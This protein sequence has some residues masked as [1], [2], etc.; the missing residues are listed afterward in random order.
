MRRVTNL[1]D[2]TEMGILEATGSVIDGYSQQLGFEYY[3]DELTEEEEE[4]SNKLCDE[5]YNT[6]GDIWGTARPPPSLREGSSERC[7]A[8]G[9][10]R[11]SRKR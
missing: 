6:K 1:R 3:R 4:L 10:P 5:K 7:W 2:E 11:F 8:A 9:A